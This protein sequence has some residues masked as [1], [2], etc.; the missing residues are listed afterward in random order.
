MFNTPRDKK[1]INHYGVHYD[2]YV[3]TSGHWDAGWPMQEPTPP[4]KFLESLLKV[5]SILKEFTKPGAEI[6]VV[7]VNQAP[8]GS[9]MQSGIDWRILTLID[10][11]NDA[12]WS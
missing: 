12:I 7:T 5:I 4:T 10:A 11:Y 1:V 3:I 2:K 6:F 9:W 8:M